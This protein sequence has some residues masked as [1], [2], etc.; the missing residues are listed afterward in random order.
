MLIPYATISV[1]LFLWKCLFHIYIDQWQ[2]RTFDFAS[3]CFLL[4]RH[5]LECNLFLFLRLS[6]NCDDKYNYTSKPPRWWGEASSSKFTPRTILYSLSE[7]GSDFITWATLF[8]SLKS[9]R[10]TWTPF[11][12]STLAEGH[13]FLEA[14]PPTHPPPL[15][16]VGRGRNGMNGSRLA[17]DG[18]SSDRSLINPGAAAAG[19]S[20]KSSLLM[21]DVGSPEIN[22]ITG[23]RLPH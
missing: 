21:A 22:G 6:G 10:K 3:T 23:C 2:Q 8:C 17:G 19:G 9:R 4:Q 13:R 14:R 5:G 16:P 12:I 20:G 11:I 18:W 1:I 7:S 15:L